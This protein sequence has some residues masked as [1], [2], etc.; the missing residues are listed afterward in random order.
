MKNKR[1]L[2][3]DLIINLIVLYLIIIG[4]FCIAG[5]FKTIYHPVPIV[6]GGLVLWSAYIFYL[7][8]AELKEKKSIGLTII[9]TIIKYKFL[10]KQL[11]Q[12]DFKKKYKRSILGIIWSFL[13]PMSMMVVQ[14]IVFSTIFKSDIENFPVYL[15]SGTI[16]FNFFTEAVGE[17][18]NAIVGNASLLTKVYVPKYIYPITKVFSTSINL[19]ISIMPLLVVMIITRQ[20]LTRALFLFPFI[21]VVLLTFTI[22]ITLI[23]SSAMVFFRDTLFLWGILSMVWMYITPLFYPETIIAERF[24]IILKINPMYHIIKFVR[25]IVMNGISPLPEE[26]G[27]CMLSAIISLLLGIFIFKKTQDKFVLYI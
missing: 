1:I 6:L 22:G 11:I 21:I 7:R 14:Y 8:D 26:Y 20:S 13:N 24:Q 9:K 12:R 5:T 3:S 27:I 4:I 16:F 10:M 2:T 15:L 25:C 23:L 19:L 17:G 18:L